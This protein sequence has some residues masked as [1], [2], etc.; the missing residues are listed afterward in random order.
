MKLN[1]NGLWKTLIDK[2]RKKNNLIVRPDVSIT[3]ASKIVRGSESF[4]IIKKIYEEFSRIL[5]IQFVLN[6]INWRNYR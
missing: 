2:N 5:M 4:T 1:H 3:I 6:Q